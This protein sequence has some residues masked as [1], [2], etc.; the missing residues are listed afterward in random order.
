MTPAFVFTHYGEPLYE[1]QRWRLPV[2]LERYLAEAME[3]RRHEG[4]IRRLWQGDASLWTS[5]DEANWLSAMRQKFGGH[6]EPRS[7]D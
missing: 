5:H 2:A 6:V 7:L 3:D 1:R 4:K